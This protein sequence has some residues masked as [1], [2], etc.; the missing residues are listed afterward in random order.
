MVSR[1]SGFT[2]RTPSTAGLAC[3]SSSTGLR[4]SPEWSNKVTFLSDIG[5]QPVA[6]DD[7]LNLKGRQPLF[8]TGQSPEVEGRKTSSPALYPSR[9]GLGV[10]APDPLPLYP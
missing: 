1:V 8:Q 2:H 9:A 10:N 4:V 3:P 7:R 5:F 6:P